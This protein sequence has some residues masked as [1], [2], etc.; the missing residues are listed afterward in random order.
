[1]K[2]E[3]YAPAHAV[4]RARSVRRVARWDDVN[5]SLVSEAYV[6]HLSTPTT[7]DAVDAGDA[8]AATTRPQRYA[9]APSARAPA[10]RSIA[11]QSAVDF[12]SLFCV[13]Q[14]SKNLELS[15][16]LVARAR[17]TRHLRGAGRARAHDASTHGVGAMT[18]STS[19]TLATF[20]GVPEMS[21]Q[22]LEAID[23]AHPSA[24]ARTV[25]AAVLASD[26]NACARGGALAS[27]TRG[28][29][30]RGA[31]VVQL[32]EWLNARAPSDARYDEGACR[33]PG[34]GARCLKMRL[35]DGARTYVAYEYDAC[36]A[37]SG[38]AMKAGMKVR[39]THPYVAEDGALWLRDENVCV[40]GGEVRALERA[41]ERVVDVFARAN[42][43]GVMKREEEAMKAAW[44]VE[45]ESRIRT[46]A[47]AD[48]SARPRG[49]GG[50]APAAASTVAPVTTAAPVRATTAAP[51]VS[52]VVR[53]T[54][55]VEVLEIDDDE[56]AR[57][58]EDAHDPIVDPTPS[59]RVTRNSQRVRDSLPSSSGGGTRGTP[60][61]GADARYVAERLNA[62][63]VRGAWT[64]IA[65]LK[66]VRDDLADD[67]K[68]VIHGWI[69]K[70][71]AIELQ[72]A[73]SAPKWRARV[74]ISDSTGYVN[75]WM[76]SSVLELA[77][78]VTISQYIAASL[79]ERKSIMDALGARLGTFCGRIKLSDFK[80]K[81]VVVFKLDQQ[82]TKFAS[83]VG[84]AL[85]ERRAE[86]ARMRHNAR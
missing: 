69:S 85:E 63:G 49:D 80:S 76:R 8:D 15:T 47:S 21:R 33:A 40:L 5:A 77:A 19:R 14:K 34:S 32:D 22:W 62:T 43:P 64:Y 65:A 83:G 35:T 51:D 31:H 12:V 60:V 1:M 7:R 52:T 2:Y 73:G 37:L 39:L 59:E 78:G 55:I 50:R 4:V 25:V 41:R 48:A 28:A 46:D 56:D 57:D 70:V 82:P 30:A 27:A 79:D 58:V 44:G 20:V 74:Q 71:G 45:A 68:P 67:D 18:T 42:R 81:N 53:E 54:Q 6:R 17:T 86:F 24:D 3:M 66:A 38:G 75:A 36:G 10:S 13:A 72:T 16:L 23:A 9:I 26:F 84:K 61:V 29:I 11:T